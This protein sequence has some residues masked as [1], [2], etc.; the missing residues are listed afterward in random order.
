MPRT[1]V[2]FEAVKLGKPVLALEYL[3]ANRS[4]I[5]HYVKACDVQCRDDLYDWI[6]KFSQDRKAAFYNETERQQFIR[7]MIAA[8]DAN[9]LTRY[10]EF[11][12]YCL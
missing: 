9:V 2:T 5:A 8:P 11:L 6:E 1:S 12:E 4:T 3:H 7:G 10:V